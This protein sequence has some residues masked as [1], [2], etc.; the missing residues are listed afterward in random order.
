MLHTGLRWR[1]GAFELMDE[2]SGELLFS[3]LQVGQYTS[4]KNDGSRPPEEERA[5]AVA[6]EVLLVR[7]RCAARTSRAGSGANCANG[8]AP[9][10][11]RAG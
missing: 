8:R 2:S 7:L 11:F 4:P 6:M 3:K 5:A 10:R 9:A 1:V